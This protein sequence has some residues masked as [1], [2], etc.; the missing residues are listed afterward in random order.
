MHS[1]I[2]HVHEGQIT[3]TLNDS[4][5]KEINKMIDNNETRQLGFFNYEFTKMPDKSIFQAKLPPEELREIFIEAYNT[6]IEIVEGFKNPMVHCGIKMADVVTQMAGHQFR[7]QK[8]T[9]RYRPD[10]DKPS[11]ASKVAYSKYLGESAGK[12]FDEWFNALGKGNAGIFWK[13]WED[14]IGL[15]S[16][17]GDK[18]KFCINK[19]NPNA[20]RITM[21]AFGR[22]FTNRDSGYWVD[23]LGVC[24]RHKM[25][26]VKDCGSYLQVDT[27][28]LGNEG[29]LIPAA[30]FKKDFNEFNNPEISESLTAKVAID[31]RRDLIK[32]NVEKDQ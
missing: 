18:T 5:N 4:I 15:R 16:T 11:V 31:M 27:R 28:I 22:V 7:D 23:L 14:S 19:K 12:V 30:L 29:V 2:K 25:N 24:Y 26:R 17:T 6:D 21:H 32:G 10:C 1:L 20:H 8:N 3:H 13:V 9:K